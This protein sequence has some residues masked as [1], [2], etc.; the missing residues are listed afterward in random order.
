MFISSLTS[1]KSIFLQA[2][3][4]KIV[5]RKL[6]TPSTSLKRISTMA[7]PPMSQTLRPPSHPEMRTLDRSAFTLTHP[8]L[9]VRLDAGKI[10]K[11]RH[12]PIM[13]GWLMDMPKAKIILE[14]PEGSSTKLIR[15][16]VQ[17][18]GEWS[19]QFMIYIR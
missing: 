18:E 6:Y 8:I 9:S 4:L 1:T 2:T 3:R 7:P 16:K 19:H 13:R 15:L 14:D 5:S 11:I 10:T 12:S 17:R